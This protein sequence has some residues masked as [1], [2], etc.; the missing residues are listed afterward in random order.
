MILSGMPGAGMMMPNTSMMGMTGMQSMAGGMMPG[1]P[2]MGT[3][4]GMNMG[5][6]NTMPGM[7]G[8][9][10]GIVIPHIFFAKKLKINQSEGILLRV[11]HTHGGHVFSRYDGDASAPCHSRRSAQRDAGQFGA[12]G[13]RRYAHRHTPAGGCGPCRHRMGH[14]PT[15]AG[16]LLCP[17]SGTLLHPCFDK[18]F[19]KTRRNICVCFTL[20]G[21]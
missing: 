5:A 6:H 12:G 11:I 19:L 9:Q 18:D 14:P 3:M 4:A 13:R 21:K 1:A 17:I 2:G 16:G 10:A 15:E 8:P 20:L 7:M